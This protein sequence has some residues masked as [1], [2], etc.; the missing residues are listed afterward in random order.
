M[1]SLLRP[2]LG[3]GIV[4]LLFAAPAIAADL[5]L[6]VVAEAEERINVEDPEGSVCTAEK[7][8]PY[9]EPVYCE[10]DYQCQVYGTGVKCD[11]V[12]TSCQ[13]AAAPP[14]EDPLCY[15]VCKKNGYSDL[16]CLDQ[17]CLRGLD[18]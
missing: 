2:V 13:C 15:C 8:C 10:G 3:I 9:D 14:C 18:P 17:C 4:L 16:F 12:F 1:R 5:E 11:G 6:E 7:D